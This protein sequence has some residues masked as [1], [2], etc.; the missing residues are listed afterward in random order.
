[1]IVSIINSLI[2]KILSLQT[3]LL[4]NFTPGELQRWLTT[5][6]STDSHVDQQYFAVAT[7]GPLIP[8]FLPTLCE[9]VPTQLSSSAPSLQP[10]AHKG[11]LF[12][13][14]TAQLRGL[15]SPEGAYRAG[16]KSFKCKISCH[17][18]NIF[19]HIWRH[20]CNDMGYDFHGSNSDDDDDDDDDGGGGGDNNNNNNNDRITNCYYHNN[21]L[22]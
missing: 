8:Q 18:V 16:L 19:V 14:C 1:M 6:D 21:L 20:E 9:A 5:Q 11:S 15:L 7:P 17:H 22:L 12:K 13:R 4:N 3:K 2:K 10:L